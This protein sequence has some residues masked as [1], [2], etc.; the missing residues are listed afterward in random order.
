[1]QKGFLLVAFVFVLN[2]CNTK[3]NQADSLTRLSNGTIEI[4]LLPE[5]GGRLVR[6]SLPGH[7]NIIQSDSALWNEPSSQQVQKILVMIQ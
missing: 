1:M 3:H 2:N 6:V 4:G 7:P 5:V